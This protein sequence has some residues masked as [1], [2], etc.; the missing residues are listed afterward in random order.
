MKRL[1]HPLRALAMAAAGFCAAIGLAGLDGAIPAAVGAACGVMAGELLGRTRVRL[2]IVLVASAVLGGF[3]VW[4]AGAATRYE[5]LPDLIGPGTALRLSTVA[6]F[7]ALALAVA[8]SLRA[9]ARRVPPLAVLELATV[10]ASVAIPFAS[11]REGVI[12]R[13]LWLADWAWRE[14]VDPSLVLLIVGGASAGVLLFVLLLESGRRVSWGTIPGMAVLAVVILLA[15][16]VAPTPEPRPTNDLGL[17]MLSQGD[18]PLPNNTPG[19]DGHGGSSTNGSGQNGNQ[20]QQGQQGQGQGQQQQQQGQGGQ[21]QQQQQ[22]GQGGQGQQQQQQG[23]GQPPP[24]PPDLELDSGAGQPP[25]P[26]AIVLLGDDYTPP[27]QMYYLRQ[28]TWTEYVG[29]RLVPPR[30]TEIDREVPRSFPVGRQQ[31]PNADRALAEGEM[32]IHADVALL[33]DH[34]R[35]FFLGTPVVWEPLPNPDPKQFSRAYRFESVVSTLDYDRMFGRSA[36]NRDWS[37]DVAAMYLQPPADPRFAELANELIA[38]LP[39]DRRADPFARAAVI[40]LHLDKNFKY[41]TKHRHAG[42]P[43]PTADFLFGDKIGYCV[44]FAHAAVYLWRSVG[45]PAR[46][47]VGYAVDAEHRRGSTLLLRGSDAHA[48]PEL[49]LDGIG[50][51]ILDITPAENLDPV[52]AAPDV[53]MQQ[54]LAEMARA[55]PPDPFV[56]EEVPAKEPTGSWAAPAALGAGLL[57]LVPLLALYAVKLWRRLA[58]W[59]APARQLP[60]VGYRLALDLVAEAGHVRER[61]ETREGFARRLGSAAPTFESIT[62]LHIAS[63]FGPPPAPTSSRAEW[64]A[65]LGQLRAELARASTASKRLLAALNPLS[66]F[67]SR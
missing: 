30:R 5:T 39:P 3:G 2:W 47:G 26:M 24:K 63:R 58:P 6:E 52:I 10:A 56:P 25:A 43:D 65:R 15:M 31:A 17:T 33:V 41:S 50:W 53:D 44:H 14:G 9:L 11:H 29:S 35:P 7:S 48:W 36:G 38:A 54:L 60:R 45:I 37:P 61:G 51:V 34:R 40:K 67:S 32:R 49:Y 46:I 22:Q 59:F 62:D 16:Q 1:R 12:G 20:P 57:M 13:P 8:T 19:S 42:V 23:Q 4:L 18:P 21:G 28:E 66:V 64:R 27:S 55:E